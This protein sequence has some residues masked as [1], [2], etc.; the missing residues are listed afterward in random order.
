MEPVDLL[1]TA[2]WILPIEPAAAALDHSAVAVR[3]G[4]IV[5]VLPTRDA[6]QRYAPARHIDRP[7]HAVLPGLIN[8]YTH[9]GNTLLRSRAAGIGFDRWLGPKTWPSEQRWLD[10]EFVRDSTEL[11]IADMVSSGTTCCTAQYFFADVVAQTAS[12]MHLRACAAVPV[13]DV[14]TPWTDSVGECLDKALRLHDEYRDDPLITTA[15]APHAVDTLDDPMLTRIKRA[16]DEIEL[17]IIAS[18]HDDGRPHLNS[19]RANPERTCLERLSRLGLLTPAF[20][21]LHAARWTPDDLACAARTGINIIHCPRSDL[22]LRREPAPV[23]ELL[24]CGVNVAIGTDTGTSNLNACLFDELRTAA[25]LAGG[26]VAA[27][28]WLRIATLNGARALNLHEST[29]SLVPGKWADLCCV[30]LRGLAMQPIG[31]PAVA[32]VH[33]AQRSDV[34]DVWVAGRALLQSGR[35][36]EYDT[37]SILARA[38]AWQQRIN[39]AADTRT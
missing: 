36:S 21:A 12:Q 33:G 24:G 27:H 34:T 26:S 28:E 13:L 5:A 25:L 8:A 38:A 39:G 35:L 1:L 20:G 11:A 19:E 2:R 17:P 18:L 9:T 22:N 16:A 23:A 6:L 37:E 29:G 14:P 15:F 7:T 31:D 32:L 3:Q 4:R 30:D 10:P